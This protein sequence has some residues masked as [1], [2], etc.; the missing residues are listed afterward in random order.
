MFSRPGRRLKNAIPYSGRRGADGNTV[1][2]CGTRE[3]AQV[4]T[5]QHGPH[6]VP[7]ACRPGLCAVLA[8]GRAFPS[9]RASCQRWGE[10]F[11]LT[12]ARLSI[13]CHA[14]GGL[15]PT[16][17]PVDRRTYILAMRSRRLEREFAAK[18]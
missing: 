16:P 8:G 3:P 2:A 18:S 14:P 6:A 17:K 7:R 5:Q 15:T 13:P 9:S 1:T 4:L 11:L 12:A 10:A